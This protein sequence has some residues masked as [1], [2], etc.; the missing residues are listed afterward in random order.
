MCALT[1]FP[2]ESDE[3]AQIEGVGAID[4]FFNLLY[5]QKIV[6]SIGQHGIKY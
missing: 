1:H 5:V 2:E 3:I 6:F 4:Y